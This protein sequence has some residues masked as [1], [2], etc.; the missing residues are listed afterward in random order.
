MRR[1]TRGFGRLEAEAGAIVGRATS[2]RRARP[3][4]VLGTAAAIFL[5]GLAPVAFVVFEI[6]HWSTSPGYGS[7]LRVAYLGAADAVVHGRNPYPPLDD[8]VLA[9]GEAYVYPPVLALA[10]APLLLVPDSWLFPVAATS[11]AILVLLILYLARVRDW[12]CYGA[13]MLWPPVTNT[14]M[15]LNVSLILAL[16]LVLAW[17]AR[18]R[19]L[20]SGLLIGSTI[21]LKLFAWP[22]L[23]WPAAMRRGRTAL[24]GI[25]AAAVLVIVPWAAIGFAGLREYPD[26]LRRVTDLESFESYSIPGALG[27]LGVDPAAGRVIALATG[28]ALV[29]LVIVYGR[30][31]D[32]RRAFVAAV[33]AALAASPIVWQHY[34]L[35]LLV[36]VA[37]SRPRF[38][39][40]WLVPLLMWVGPFTG[41]GSAVQTLVV[42]CSA[43][44]VGVVCLRALPS[45]SDRPLEQ[46]TVQKTP[47]LP[48]PHDVRRWMTTTRSSR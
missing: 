39:V 38:S 47:A 48:R 32:D 6:V 23:A 42:T 16:L 35:A 25:A 13:A 18:N 26:L 37:V 2:A 12:R 3:G 28:I 46:G 41:N 7:D 14:L 4:F 45:E 10:A 24:L 31:G 19:P 11:A 30:R 43:V 15:T 34:Y 20:I 40:V 33:L 8:P 22:L 1:G 29:A 44:V 5:L 27:A 36:V 17:R 9:R 21:A